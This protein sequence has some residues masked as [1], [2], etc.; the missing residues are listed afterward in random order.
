M[1]AGCRFQAPPPNGMALAGY[2]PPPMLWPRGFT[3]L[4]IETNKENASCL[5]WSFKN[6]RKIAVFSLGA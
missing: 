5:T 3:G 1:F 4:N 2:S 6:M